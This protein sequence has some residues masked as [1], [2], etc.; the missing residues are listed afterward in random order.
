MYENI[1]KIILKVPQ[2]TPR[3]ALYMETG[4]MSPETIIK[5]NR[6]SMEARIK[7]GNNTLMKN[8]IELKHEN[9]WAT[10]NNQIKQEMMVT[11][12]DLTGSCYST[13]KILKQKAKDHH[14]KNLTKTGSEKSKIHFLKEGYRCHAI[15]HKVQITIT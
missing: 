6:L 7:R 11:D 2:G 10:Q 5:K 9:S 14:N 15:K 13:K 3:E 1:I 4:L 12:N 8:I